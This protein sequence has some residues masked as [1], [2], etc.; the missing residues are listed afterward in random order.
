MGQH[1]A[2]EYQGTVG[3]L[4]SGGRSCSIDLCALLSC[5]LLTIPI[6][7]GASNMPSQKNYTSCPLILGKNEDGIGYGQRREPGGFPRFQKSNV[8]GAAS[9]SLFLLLFALPPSSYLKHGCDGWSPSSHLV[10]MSMMMI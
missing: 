10:S 9:D 6:R 5:S 3:S 4:K 2:I 8:K 7:F 1:L